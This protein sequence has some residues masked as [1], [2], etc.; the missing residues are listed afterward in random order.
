[1]INRDDEGRI[2]EHVNELVFGALLGLA[3]FVLL[4]WGIEKLAGRG[5]GSGGTGEKGNGKQ[6]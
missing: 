6:E 3:C 1:M 2:Q 4:V 5:G